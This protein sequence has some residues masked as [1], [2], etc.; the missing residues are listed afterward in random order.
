[1]RTLLEKAVVHLLNGDD[2]KAAALFHKFMVERAR[3]IHESLRQDESE[4]DNLDENWDSEIKEEEYF[5]DNELGDDTETAD[6]AMAGSDSPIDGD[7]GNDTMGGD[8]VADD[9]TMGASDDDMGDMGDDPD[10][11]FGDPD[12][13]GEPGLEG[14]IDDLTDKIDQLTAEFD[15]VMSEFH[16][17]GDDDANF[18][19]PSEEGGDDADGGLGLDGDVPSDDSGSDFG[20]DEEVP[21]EGG[22]NHDLAGRMEDDMADDDHQPVP[23]GKM[24]DFIK[25]KMKNKDKKNKEVDEDDEGGDSDELSDITESVLAEL[26]RIAPPSMTAEVKGVGSNSVKSQLGAGNTASPVPH[27]NVMDR[28]KG[29]PVFTKGPTHKGYAKEE[30]PTVAGADTLVKNVRPENR[31]KSFKDTMKTVDAKGDASA[32][33]HKDFAPGMPKATKS[34]IDG[35]TK[36]G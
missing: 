18:G 15:R 22:D 5:D 30:S 8:E 26:D 24:P 4:E 34:I 16:D 2:N 9:D 25:D 11:N 27:H 17:D 14:K 29:E 6:P 32:I 33:L 35:K 36:K 28:A 19:D 31:R 12:E 7:M 23:E 10:A 3:Q 1:M 21:D 13:G 20:G